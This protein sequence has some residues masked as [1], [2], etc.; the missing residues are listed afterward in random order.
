[1][2][3]LLSEGLMSEGLRGLMPGGANVGGQVTALAEEQN[4]KIFFLFYRSAMI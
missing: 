1:M 2:R 4:A 3:E